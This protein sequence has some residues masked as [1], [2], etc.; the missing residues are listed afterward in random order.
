L[1]RMV[2][3]PSGPHADSGGTDWDL[4]LCDTPTNLA[5]NA[6]CVME[7]DSEMRADPA[8]ML[9]CGGELVIRTAAQGRAIHNWGNNKTRNAYAGAFRKWRDTGAFDGV[10]WD[11]IQ[12]RFNRAADAS[13]DY[14]TGDGRTGARCGPD[15][16]LDFH[17][18]EVQMVKDGREAIG[19]DNVTICNDGRGLGN[20]TFAINDSDSTLAGKP[21]CSVSTLFAHNVPF[22]RYAEW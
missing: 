4:L 8:Q 17:E 1:C 5:H 20:W 21:M 11:G 6:T 9:H 19:W 13:Q 15:E 16:I 7:F 3:K 18:G 10:F 12:H 2:C 22:L 14:P